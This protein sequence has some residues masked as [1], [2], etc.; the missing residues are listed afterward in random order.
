MADVGGT[1]WRRSPRTGGASQGRRE[2]IIV[3]ACE[4]LCGL[5]VCVVYWAK[6]MWPTMSLF[7]IFFCESFFFS[8]NNL[9]DS[10]IPH[11]YIG[12]SYMVDI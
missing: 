6:P 9:A 7:F 8:N 4:V 10:S 5:G 11:I 3:R 2:E 1:D 12:F